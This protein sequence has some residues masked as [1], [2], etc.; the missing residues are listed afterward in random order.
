VGTLGDVVEPGTRVQIIKD[1][2]WNGPWPS[3][4]MGFIDPDADCP[5]RVVDLAKIP[6]INVPDSDRGPMREFLVHFDEPQL[7]G[8]GAGPYVSAVIWEK[9]LRLIE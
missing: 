6:E 8:E 3:E 5:I 1:P 4:P 9:Y 7:D 2:R